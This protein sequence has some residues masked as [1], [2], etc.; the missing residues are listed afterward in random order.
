MKQ[1]V[2]FPIHNSPLQMMH[3]IVVETQKFNVDAELVLDSIHHITDNAC[4]KLS[5]NFKEP[6]LIFKFSSTLVLN[7]TF[8][9]EA[10]PDA[11]VSVKQGSTTFH[12]DSIQAAAVNEQLCLIRDKSDPSKICGSFMIRFL[13]LV[14]IRQ[15]MFMNDDIRK[16]KVP[17]FIGHRG[18]GAN[19]Y[20]IPLRENTI[21]SFNEA[22]RHKG[23]IG[24]ELDVSFTADRKL[25]VYHDLE[26]SGKLAPNGST[27]LTNHKTPICS[28]THDNMCVDTDD[29]N[30]PLLED[31][32]R[33]LEPSSAGIVIELKY[34]SNSY[35]RNHPEFSKFTR[36]E[37]VDAVLDCVEANWQYVSTRW[38][39]FSSFDPDICLYLHT[40]LAQT[41]ALIVHNLW[42]GHENDEEDNTVDFNDIRNRSWEAAL[43]Q[44]GG[45][46]VA[47]EASFV[48]S[49][50]FPPDLN[51]TTLDNTLVFSYG[52]A[53]LKSVNIQAQLQRGVHAF[54]IDDMTLAKN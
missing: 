14:R 49:H 3:I 15:P 34:V 37:L 32:L 46:G 41:N 6:F 48:L 10:L 54:F 20:G 30:P 42:L 23:V 39:V 50:N 25:V 5:C 43:L 28:L 1:N 52:R 12:S 18:S 45:N 4:A 24:I 16:H 36:E 27:C 53:N 9:V 21:L 29:R 19:S 11:L 47:L 7:F 51:R 2:D 38:L 13:S 33:S 31:V 8:F 35:A 17:P 40:A 44:S 26:W 22:M